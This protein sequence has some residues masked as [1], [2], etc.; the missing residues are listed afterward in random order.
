MMTQVFTQPN[1]IRNLIL[2]VL[3]G[4]AMCNISLAEDIEVYRGQSVGIR[5]NSLFVMDTSGSMGWYEEA[6]APNYDPNTLYPNQ[7]FDPVLYYFSNKYEGNGKKDLDLKE[8]QKKFFTPYALV[9][10]RAAQALEET[11]FYNGRFKRWDVSKKDWLPNK[12]SKSVPNGSR[13]VSALIECKADEGEHPENSYVDTRG[14]DS[15]EQYIVTNNSWKLP[16]DYSKQWKTHIEHLYTGNF[17]NFQIEL[18]SLE[19]GLIK[20][21]MQIVRE[22]AVAV[23]K[24]TSGIRLGLMRF[25]SEMDG[26]FVDIAVDDVENISNE[27]EEKVSE[28]I[29]WNGTP[30]SESYYEAALYFRG[31][32]ITFGRDSYSQILK[33]GETLIRDKDGYIDKGKNKYTTKI[34]DTPSVALSRAGN[35]YISPLDSACQ[36]SSTIILFTDGAPSYDDQANSKIKKMIAGIN[37]PAGSGLTHSC[38]GSGGCAD[39][40]AYYLNNFDQNLALAGKQ[41]IRT[42]V[43]GG[44]FDGSGDNGDIRY[45]ESIAH[46]G[47]GKYYSASDYQSIVDALERTLQETSDVPVTFVAPSVAA[48]SYNSLEHLDQLYYAMFVPQP[49]N[50]WNG[51]LKSYRL[52]SA[53]E[54]IDAKGDPAILDSGIFAKESRSYWT[55]DDI[56]D[57]EDVVIGGAASRL[58]ASYKIYTH[59]D[60]SKTQLKTAISNTTVSKALLGLNDNASAE[61][62]QQMVDWAN[63]VSLTSDDGIRR[64]MEDP[65]HSRP[66]VVSYNSTNSNGEKVQEG[67]VFVGTNSGYLHA[68]KADKK[69][70]KEHFSYIPKELLK[71]IP[72]Y[73]DGE[74]L[75][76]KT[77]G[78]DGA[79]NYWH[80]DKNFNGEVD[81]QSDEKVLLF[82]GLRRGGRHYYALDITDPDKPKF[83]WQ[84]NGGEGDFEQL[85]QTWSNLVLAK[86]KWKGQSKVVLLVGGGYDPSEDDQV[87]RTK[88]TMGNAVYMIDPET[89]KRLWH[90]S[91]A[92][93]SLNL[94]AMSSAITSDVTILDFDGDMITDYFFVS[95][96]GGRIWRF[97]INKSNQGKGDFAKAGVIF[98]AN[99]N[100]ENS[101][102]QSYQRF[103][104][105]PSIS[106]FRDQ[107]NNDEYLSLAIGSGFRAHP[108]VPNGQD[109]FYVIK[110]R[111]LVKAPARYE[112][113]IPEDLIDLQTSSFSNRSTSTSASWADVSLTNSQLDYGWKIELEVGEKVLSKALTSQGD[114][115]FTTF[116]P[117]VKESNPGS[118]IADVGNS[119][120]YTL[121]IKADNDANNNGTLPV[122]TKTPMGNIGIPA[123]PIEVRT[124]SKGD[125]EFCAENPGHESCIPC[126]G[127]DCAIDSCETNGSVILSGT[128]NL[129]GEISRCDLMRKKYWLQH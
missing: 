23:V 15:N 61:L 90:A 68:F 2:V 108:L 46:H 95:D 91:N 52:N 118:C 22:A 102:G 93:S 36:T 100:A 67:V 32:A 42:F 41:V 19:K 106:Y 110:D 37:F 115:Y 86:V 48:N 25:D 14:R 18:E 39:E 69:E 20:S 9:C 30:L 116:S 98:D 26:G 114:V 1:F 3:T 125:E 63:R 50:N 27:F 38:S 29:P 77:Y 31:D 45:M 97:D 72:S 28:Y 122:V 49:G 119:S 107:K 34:I 16:R 85:G 17:I 124:T 105:A 60:E 47:G 54:V 13:D 71:N 92:Y 112:T 6:E 21:R 40:L 11:G 57:G 44:F 84:I 35:Q 82:F 79:I 4:V 78:I 58:T 121:D 103:Y 10:E 76:D 120:A 99:P 80:M 33:P 55:D 56:D 12:S 65:I 83:A 113:L 73:V 43:I 87:R 104:Y 66:M 117:T 8:L 123:E 96:V 129:G 74:D 128:Q 127:D 101:I 75:L 51:N 109:S 64:E 53:G 24:S 59:L 111:N 94:D 5:Q 7:G 62:H 81:A 126:E 89:G 70:F 88:H